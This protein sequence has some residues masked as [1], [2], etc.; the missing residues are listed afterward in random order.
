MKSWKLLLRTCGKVG[1]SIYQ[2]KN[3]VH[4]KLRQSSFFHCFLSQG[5]CLSFWNCNTIFRFFSYIKPGTFKGRP[6]R[7]C[8]CQK[9]LV[10]DKVAFSVSCCN[11]LRIAIKV[12]TSSEKCTKNVPM[13]K[14][15]ISR[16]LKALA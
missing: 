14:K 12:Y 4:E 6:L 13:G 7:A 10:G 5:S 15:N 9:K 8:D 3:R 2:A 1:G 16:I 11:C